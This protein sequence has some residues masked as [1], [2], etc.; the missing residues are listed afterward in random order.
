MAVHSALS[1]AKCNAYAIETR[2]AAMEESA[3]PKRANA[4]VISGNQ[5]KILK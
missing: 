3:Y 5:M 4:V 2:T 1:Q